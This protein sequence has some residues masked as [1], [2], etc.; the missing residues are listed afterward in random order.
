LLIFSRVEDTVLSEYWN[1]PSP[2]VFSNP[3]GRTVCTNF[4]IVTL[5]L[6]S[7]PL[8]VFLVVVNLATD[9]RQ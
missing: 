5:H 9:I 3:S 6:K 4:K 8:R 7:I 1:S 2:M